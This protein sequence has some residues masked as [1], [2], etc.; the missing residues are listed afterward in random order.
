MISLFRRYLETWPVRAFFGLMVVAFVV[1]GVGDVVRVV[2]TKTWL[3]KVGGQTIEPQQF[4]PTFQRELAQAQRRLPSGQDMTMAQ[5]HEVADRALQQMIGQVAMTD[6]ERRLR[7]VV[8][9]AMV[10]EAVFSMPAF[11]DKS[12][13]FDRAR[14]DAALRANNM[15]EG[16]FLAIVR[17]DLARGEVVDAITAGVVPPDT[18][19][20][21][22]Y[23]F[24]TE[25]RS[26]QMA[27]F[28]F[29]AA[30]TPPAPSEAELHRWYANHPD[31]F[32]I[33]EFR[34]IKAIILTVE[35][36]AKGLTASDE[37]LHAWYDAH[38]S[39][40]VQPERR[41]IEVLITPDQAKTQ[42]LAKQW[43]AGMDWTTMQKA[44]E[45]AGGSGVALDQ[46]TQV[47]IPDATLAQAAFAA[48]HDEVTAPVKA[49][50]GWAVLRV[51]TITPGREQS[52]DQVKDDVRTHVL[53]EKA[54]SML[55][56]RAN[57]VDDVL[58][59]GTGLD[60]LPTDLGLVGVSG[61]MDAQGKT[62]NEEPAPIPGPPELRDALIAA[63]F[64]H[65]PGPPSEM[66]EVPIPGG[67][68]AFYAV[69]VEQVMPPSVR[70][71]DDV[72][73]QAA[74]DWQRD[75]QEKTQEKA[76][77][78]MLVALKGGQSMADAAAKA[79]VTVRTTPL[80]TRDAT[81]D[82]M[83]PQLQRVLFGLKP[84]EPA[85]V[86]TPEAFVVAVA[87]K[88]ETPDPKGNQAQYASVHDV[89]TRTL[90]TD[91]AQSFADALRSR[92]SPQ[93]NQSVL[94]SFVQQ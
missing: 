49:S 83:P 50:L 6:E 74:Q 39:Q 4:Q 53:A 64:A 92:A 25:R 51:T 61:T 45:A 26:A 75:A 24:E 12:G 16:E 62:A 17:G 57:K 9:D 80:V 20:R 85:M 69:E 44:A 54:A 5:R 37:E 34:R 33:P 86:Q 28:P 93:I 7:I 66:T 29:A 32:R 22:A 68:S 38:K 14:L 1:W 67:G 76:A 41:S 52:L 23:D 18:L 31:A 19:V 87:D 72:K 84:G 43:A 59:T 70:P 77:T 73:D 81:A 27:E 79:G 71:F 46:A 2:G 65:S 82:G 55:Y 58:G 8:P 13:Q 48:P 94:D 35:T 78:A 30:P 10:R 11:L 42:A 89:L 91:Y 15:T 3:V 90:A 88:I 63:A 40:F 36:I 21:R 60:K 56:D 47:Q